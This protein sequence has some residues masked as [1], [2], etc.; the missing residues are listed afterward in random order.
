MCGGSR[1]IVKKR[2]KGAR[3]P[4]ESSFACPC[5]WSRETAGGYRGQAVA[6]R[7][8]DD[9]ATGRHARGAR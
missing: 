3:G 1:I 8:D 2:P 7:P 4:K 6:P 5:T 9:D